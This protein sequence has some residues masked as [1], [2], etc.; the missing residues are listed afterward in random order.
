MFLRKS[1]RSPSESG[2]SVI[3]DKCME[4]GGERSRNQIDFVRRCNSLP[5]RAWVILQAADFAADSHPNQSPKNHRIRRAGF[6]ECA[7]SS[8]TDESS[9]LIQRRP[10]PS[11]QEG[12]TASTSQSSKLIPRQRSRPGLSVEHAAFRQRSFVA[13]WGVDGLVSGSPSGACAGAHESYCFY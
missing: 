11:F 12:D 6:H 8:T 7:G 13:K 5:L 1:G 3:A 4:A 2:T 9:N 10:A